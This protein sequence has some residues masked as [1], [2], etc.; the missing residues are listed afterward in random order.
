MP[1]I[2][3]NNRSLPLDVIVNI[4]Q[5]SSKRDLC[6]YSLVCKSWSEVVQSILFSVVKIK[7]LSQLE[8]LDETVSRKPRLGEQ[9]Q[10][11]SVWISNDNKDAT[12]LVTKHLTNL[13]NNGLPNL[14]ELPECSLK[15][16]NPVLSALKNSRL[17]SL[18]VL[19]P[20]GGRISG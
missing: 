19:Y 20:P 18:R 7:S 13:L 3:F 10:V 16:Y 2:Y 6:N 1:E 9:V 14:L 5:K 4:M 12:T 11:L 17:K 15:S 8:T